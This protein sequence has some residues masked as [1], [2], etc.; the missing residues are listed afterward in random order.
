MNTF[1]KNIIS[2]Y[3]EKG[4]EWLRQLPNRVSEIAKTWYLTNLKPAE[5]LSYNYVLF[6]LQD[7]LPIVLK[8][9]PD[10]KALSTE[11]QALEA[12]SGYGAMKILAK[13]EDALL[14]EQAVPGEILKAYL[15]NKQR[16]ALSIACIVAQKLHCAPVSKNKIFPHMKDWLAALDKDW[17][18]PREFLL[19]AR[20][21]KNKLLETSPATDVLLHGDLHH[22]NILS[23][24]YEWRVIDPKGVIGSPV[25]EV[26]AFIREPSADIPFIA[27]TLDFDAGLIR[28]WYFVHL[29]LAACWNVEDGLSPQKFLNLANHSLQF[30]S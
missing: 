12:F 25:H 5:N 22:E 15:P 29:I 20:Q 16:E 6:G 19:K 24:G 17:D 10:N 3:G 7:S 18:I 28:Q 8:I 11:T 27:D 2:L 13:M 14:L 4:S 26:W 30:I 23:H 21:L 9:S 1:E